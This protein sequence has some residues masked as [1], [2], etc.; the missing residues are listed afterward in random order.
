[1]VQIDGQVLPPVVDEQTRRIRHAVSLRVAG[2][3][4]FRLRENVTD[5]VLGGG[6]QF[7]IDAD[8]VIAAR[9]G[10]YGVLLPVAGEVE[11]IVRRT[12]RV[13]DILDGLRRYRVDAIRGD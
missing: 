12:V 8:G 6:G 4:I 13:R 3:V 7:L 5:E 2:Q 11:R 9:C 10:V 1:M